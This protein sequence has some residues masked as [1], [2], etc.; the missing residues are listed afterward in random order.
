MESV[1]FEF[2]IMSQITESGVYVL[3]LRGES[4][5]DWIEQVGECGD[6]IW[7]LQDKEE[8]WQRS[9]LQFLFEGLSQVEVIEDRSILLL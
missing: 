8:A 9:G 6:W 3:L 2:H 4:E 5:V 7:L 1:G